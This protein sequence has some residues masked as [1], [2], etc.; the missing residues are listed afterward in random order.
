MPAGVKEAFVKD[1]A[2]GA[3]KLSHDEA[4]QFMQNL[5]NTGYFQCETWAW[6]AW[7]TFCE[8]IAVLKDEIK[9]TVVF[10]LYTP[11]CSEQNMFQMHY[12]ILHPYWP[13][14]LQIQF[15]W[16]LT[17]NYRHF[18]LWHLLNLLVTVCCWTWLPGLLSASVYVY[19][20]FNI[21]HFNLKLYQCLSSF[22]S[23]SLWFFPHI[24][25]LTCT[26][27]LSVCLNIT[28]FSAVFII[29][30]CIYPSNSNLWLIAC[31]SSVYKLTSP[32]CSFLTCLCDS[33][34]SLL[35]IGYIWPDT[36]KSLNT[37]FLPSHTFF[38]L[39][40]TYLYVYS[41]PPN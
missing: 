31:K 34:L 37:H 23:H 29:C 3:G 22:P 40:D 28:Q 9:A 16:E 27:S 36:L 39:F 25:S 14:L 5:E 20:Y 6:C 11:I 32:T 15:S 4:K 21:L 24:S 1:V 26:I 19:I 35:H 8:G 30:I 18:K 17:K 10:S 38:T 13:C 2:C 7:H 12:I 41:F 33:S